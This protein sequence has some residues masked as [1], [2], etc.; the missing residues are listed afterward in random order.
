[1]GLRGEGLLGH[2]PPSS[3][4]RES[5]GEREGG[6]EGKVLGVQHAAH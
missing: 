1:M 4:A 2:A 3:T 5:E 6:Y